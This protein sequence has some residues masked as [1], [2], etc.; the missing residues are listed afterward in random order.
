MNGLQFF[1]LF[2]SNA[3]VSGRWD[4]G[5]G[6]MYALESRLRLERFLH[7]ARLEP[8]ILGQQAGSYYFKEDHIGQN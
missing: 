5:N 6:R 7:L 3:V 2:N 8:R 4:G 1:V